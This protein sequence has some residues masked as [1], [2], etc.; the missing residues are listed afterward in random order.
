MGTEIEV[1][2]ENKNMDFLLPCLIWSLLLSAQL[3]KTEVRKLCFLGAPAIQIDHLEPL[4]MGGAV[5]Y[6]HKNSC[7]SWRVIFFSYP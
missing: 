2:Y 5:T 7:I 4:I 3:S 6:L 1:I